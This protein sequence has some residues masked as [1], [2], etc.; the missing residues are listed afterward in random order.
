MSAVGVHQ[1][2][3][4]NAH[5]P[6]NQGSCLDLHIVFLCRRKAKRPESYDGQG[7]LVG[8]GGGGGMAVTP[9]LA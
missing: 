2:Y 4:P 9:M 6:E 7:R 3:T 5:L 1:R 8:A